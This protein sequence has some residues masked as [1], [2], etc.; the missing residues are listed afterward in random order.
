MCAGVCRQEKFSRTGAAATFLSP[1]DQPLRTEVGKPQAG[2]VRA[3]GNHAYEWTLQGPNLFPPPNP[4]PT[5]V[6][7]NAADINT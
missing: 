6:K 4:L 5:L 3:G 2:L 1:E 7:I